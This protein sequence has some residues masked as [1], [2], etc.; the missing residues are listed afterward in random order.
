M[1]NRRMKPVRRLYF[2]FGHLTE[3]RLDAYEIFSA[4]EAAGLV[5]G[6]AYEAPAGKDLP[7]HYRETEAMTDL[8]EVLFERE[9]RSI[10][11]RE[12]K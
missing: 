3:P 12:L 8:N 7:T 9:I 6:V 5:I 11:K 1:N 2:Q 10:L 4:L